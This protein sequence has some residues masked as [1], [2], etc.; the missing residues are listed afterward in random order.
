MPNNISLEEYISQATRGLYGNVFGP[1]FLRKQTFFATGDILTNTFGRKVWHALNNRTVFYNAVKKVIWGPTAGWRVRTDRGVGRSRPIGEGATVG[2]GLPTVDVSNIVNVFS[3]PRIVGTTFG[4][5]TRAI[6]ASQLEGGIGDI[7]AIEQENSQI[8]HIKEI[9]QELLAGSAYACSGGD[10]DTAI[11][12][13]AAHRTHFKVGDLVGLFDTTDDSYNE[14]TTQFVDVDSAGA[15][16]EVNAAWPGGL[17]AADGDVVY[18]LSRAGLTSIDDICM[19]DSVAIHSG[20][21]AARVDVYNQTTRTAGTWNAGALVSYNAGVGRDL[22]LT[23]IDNAI[24]NMRVNG[25]EPKLMLM[26]YDQYY[27]LERL[28]QAQQRF[29]GQTTMQ[30]GV[31]SEKTY[32]GTETGL[33]LATYQGIPILCD[34]DAPHTS[35]ATDTALGSNVYLL[36]TDYLEIGVAQTPQYYENRDYFAAGAMVVRG[37]V[38]TMAELRC[39]N[40][41]AQSKLA[42]LNE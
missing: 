2:A 38:Y 39:T 29:M 33:V 8:D 34:V 15:N 10:T 28:L 35:S 36:D 1:D 31:G 32:P 17:S 11:I 6:F 41:W 7:L 40:I 19:E 30:V 3:L 25:A 23:L 27:R 12:G 14:G 16:L 13:V 18:I 4:V 26:G 37:L 20:G 5:N 24:R 9:N 42:D 22:S 21:G